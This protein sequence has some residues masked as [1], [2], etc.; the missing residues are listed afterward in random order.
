LVP[1]DLKEGAGDGWCGFA[2]RLS[3]SISKWGNA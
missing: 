1:A 3:C 2:E